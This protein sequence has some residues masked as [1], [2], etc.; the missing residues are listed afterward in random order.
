MS[1]KRPPKE[2]RSLKPE[3][4]AWMIDSRSKIQHLMAD[5]YFFVKNNPKLGK[6]NR[7]SQ[8]YGHLVLRDNLDETGASIWMRRGG[9]VI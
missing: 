1:K 2:F 3:L 5:L 7:E 8:L 9:R 6:L 4:T